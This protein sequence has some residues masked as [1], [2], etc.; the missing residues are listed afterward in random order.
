MSDFVARLAINAAALIVAVMIVPRVRFDFG[1]AWWRLLLVA[2]LFG[3]IN[4]Y[5]RPI[6][7]ALS[8]P[9]NLIALGLVGL[10]INTAMVLL[11]AFVGGQLEL[12][13]TL[14]GWPPGEFR[15]EVVTAALLT[16]IV[17]SI[18][19]TALGLVRRVVPGV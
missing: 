16:A 7:S 11:L 5:I 12:G 1:D 13:F 2:A 14:A 18:V 4:A 10:I 8:L 9:L 17:I 19:S 3:L 15:L 6:V